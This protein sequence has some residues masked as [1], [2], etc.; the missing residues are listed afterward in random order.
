MKTRI[1]HTRIWEDEWFCGL[2]NDGQKLFLYLITNQRINIC[3]IYRITDRV[4]YFDTKIRL[5]RLERTKDEVSELGKITFYKG[6][7]HVKNA[8]QLGGYTGEKNME[9]VK[10]EMAEIP[11]DVK[12]CFLKG[13]CDRVSEKSDRVSEVSAKLDTS[14][15]HKSEIINHKSDS[16]IDFLKNIPK[17]DED[18]FI[19]RF[20]LSVKQLQNKAE[21]LFLY[22]EAKG[23]AYKNYRSFLLN[24]VK[25]DFPERPPVVEAPKIQEKPISEEQRKKNIEHTDKIKSQ[26]REKFKIKK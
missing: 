26:I 6:W 20:D 14:I 21:S 13:I 3:G 19:Q 22:C 16:S 8:Q 7:V 12:K 18:Y 9:A 5:E 11:E 10:K 24:A 1:V 4:I 15:N 25:K 2:S 23:K 17:E